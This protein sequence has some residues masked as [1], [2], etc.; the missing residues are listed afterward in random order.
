MSIPHHDQRR[1]R[2][3]KRRGPHVS[4]DRAHHAPLALTDEGLPAA[5]PDS[6]RPSPAVFVSDQSRAT[7]P[8]LPR[9]VIAGSVWRGP[10]HERVRV[11]ETGNASRWRCAPATAAR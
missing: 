3:G 7:Y 2:R 8:W 4:H 6:P 10:S 11:D 5:A 9:R 1:S